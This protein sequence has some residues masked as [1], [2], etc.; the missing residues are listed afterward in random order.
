MTSLGEAAAQ[1][2]PKAKLSPDAYNDC[3][4]LAHWASWRQKICIAITV[5]SSQ[6]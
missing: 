6:H 3:N 5:G 4:W 1:R 2:G